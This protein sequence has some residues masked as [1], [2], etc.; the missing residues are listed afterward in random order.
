[1]KRWLYIVLLLLPLLA[2]E[3]EWVNDIEASDPEGEVEI[4]FTVTRDD[5]LTKALGEDPGL[6]TMH[7]AVF[8]SSHYLKQYVKAIPVR[9]TEPVI[10]PETGEETGKYKYKDRDSTGTNIKMPQY[11][12]SVKIALSNSRRF[13]HFIGNAPESIPFGKD[14]DVLPSLIGQKETGFWQ[15]REVP[16]I[17]AEVDEDG[18]YIKPGG[19]KRGKEDDYVVSAE[20]MKYFQN[21]PLIRNWAKV[22]LYAEPVAT[23]HFIPESF[24][25]VNMPKR[26]TLVP[27]GGTKGFI[28]NYK[29]L[30]FD[31]LT[32][33][34]YQYTGNLPETVEFDPLTPDPDEF[35]HPEQYAN[36]RV[37]KYNEPADPDHPV[38]DELAAAYLY[39]RPIPNSELQ[40]TYV[41][42]YGRYVNKQDSDVPE[43]GK[44]CYYKVDLMSKG[45]YYPILRNFKYKIDIHRI[46]AVGH[47]T[48][49]EA[50]AGAGSADVSADINA[51]HL[52]DISDG[53]RRMAVQPWMA[54]TYVRA[55]EDNLF[56]A[57]YDNITVDDPQPNLKEKTELGNRYV[58]CK[59][60]PDLGEE[61]NI[62]QNISIGEADKDKID[63]VTGKENDNYGWRRIHFSVI[64][65]KKATVRTQT[66]RIICKSN[67]DPAGPGEED[68]TPLYRDVVIS[69]MPTQEMR[70]SFEKDRILRVKGEEVQMNVSL[71]DGLIE[72]MFP[73][74]FKIE[75]INKTLTP[76]TSKDNNNLPVLSGTSPADETR[77]SF[78]FQRTLTWAEYK[79]LTPRLDFEDDSRWRTFPCYFIT[80]CDQSATEVCVANEFFYLEKKTFSNY[81]SF[82]NPR[83]TSPIPYD[84]GGAVTVSA[85]MMT[86]QDSY[87]EKVYL[88]LKNLVP[89]DDTWKPESS[90]D[91][92]GKYAYTPTAQNMNFSLKTVAK[93]G[94]VSVTL[95]TESGMYEEVTLLPKRF[96]NV[97][98]IDGVDMP[99]STN[100]YSNVAWGYVNGA[101]NN[102][103]VLLGFYTDAAE[104][105]PSVWLKSD[106]GE[107]SIPAEFSSAGGYDLSTQH[108][109]VTGYAGQENYHWAELTT[110][111]G[112]EKE[113][114]V[115]LSANGYVEA[116]VSAPRFKGELSSYTL[117]ANDLGS[118][119]DEGGDIAISGVFRLYLK[120]S[121]GKEPSKH[122][123]SNGILL[124]AGGNYAW[125]VEMQSSNDNIYP[126][127]VQFTYY[128][129]D[130]AL[131]K[132]RSAEPEQDESVYYEYSG[133]R[134]NYIWIPPCIQSDKG[135]SLVM[136]AYP[137]RDIV[138]TGIVMRGFRGTVGGDFGFGEDLGEGGEL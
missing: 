73:L 66:L 133:N 90:G 61:S 37:I 138:I 17:Y 33:D 53:T 88:D 135:Y 89:A 97:D 114:S 15:M 43:E 56:V 26:G 79:S 67:P 125:D 60:I 134:Y 5:V 136:E 9:V 74:E 96:S 10:D 68:E 72:S 63:P 32:G 103:P 62:I 24:A 113:A 123:A 55:G 51:S 49:Q 65:P 29:N 64:D 80:N 38:D 42:I 40:P 129:A 76:D 50:A 83:Y 86:K 12:F 104:L 22:L 117:D 54:K 44:M 116:S 36:T 81:E 58:D 115:T 8:G 4:T 39:E 41:I 105:H 107:L 92:A 3:R 120:P 52:S 108:D 27:Y 100:I 137:D 35:V 19:G 109:Q 128:F 87:D 127:Y 75:A 1:M 132:P 45:E 101:G 95:S 78:Y 69:L 93:G 23:S 99:S 28:T 48:P 85:S 94:D 118:I 31:V 16:G 11:T 126:C 112:S 84:P 20:T 18:D 25:I 6:E 59:L 57:F 121:T 46:T 47:E 91:F 13:I 77:Q 124:P 14:Y 122:A 30:S 34:E 111:A 70:V 2:C 21:I 102:R 106:G 71:P 119:V 98:F 131:K 82:S 130:G 110:G 7:V